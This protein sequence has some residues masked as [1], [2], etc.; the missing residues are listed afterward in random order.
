MKQFPLSSTVPFGATVL[1][2][3]LLTACSDSSA[4][5]DTTKSEQELTQSVIESEPLS[6]RLPLTG[7][8]IIA[9]RSGKRI[10][11]AYFS[12]SAPVQK[13]RTQLW[14]DAKNVCFDADILN[15]STVLDVT[16]S[17]E[18]ERA[19]ERIDINGR[20]G[21]YVTLLPQQLGATVVY[22]SD[23]LWQNEGLP[24]D[25][26]LS[27]TAAQGYASIPSIGLSPLL[28]IERLTPQS[29][30]LALGEN[31]VQWQAVPDTDATIWLQL[32]GIRGPDDVDSLP[33][34]MSVGCTLDDDGVF[35]LPES[36][37]LAL[38]N[39]LYMSVSLARHRERVFSGVDG[40]VRLVQRSQN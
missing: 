28:P 37:R 18:F 31:A 11:D 36:V 17:P 8:V 15:P 29:G 24:E 26:L 2:A 39:P 35:E 38:G 19:M 13:N 6:E 10:I 9:E 25:A 33:A 20:A 1:A 34:L 4:P 40:N 21:N 22:A 12:R 23:A 7:T 14:S 3:T 27:L 16:G 30:Q 5:T 32:S